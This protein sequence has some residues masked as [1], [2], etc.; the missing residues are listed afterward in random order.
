MTLRAIHERFNENVTSFAHR[1]L[2]RQLAA[3]LCEILG[4]DVDVNYMQCQRCD[5]VYWF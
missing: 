5:E 1:F 4:H 2:S 3:F